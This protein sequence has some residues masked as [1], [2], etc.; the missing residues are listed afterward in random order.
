MRRIKKF[1]G[2][3]RKEAAER[4]KKLKEE[5]KKRAADMRKMAE[6]RNKE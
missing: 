6:K 2:K 1:K 5:W 3:S 4:N